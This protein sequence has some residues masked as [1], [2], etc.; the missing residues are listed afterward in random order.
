MVGELIAL[1][2]FGGIFN[3]INSNTSTSAPAAQKAAKQSEKNS[4]KNNNHL[5]GETTIK[6]VY[7]SAG[8]PQQLGNKIASGGQGTVY[9]LKDLPGVVVKIY[10]PATLVKH[11]KEFEE[12]LSAAVTKAK[13]FKNTAICWPA[14]LVYNEKKE[15]IGY[16]MRKAEG[17]MFSLLAHPKNSAKHFPGLQRSDIVKVLISLSKAVRLLHK[18]DIVVGDLNACNILVNQSTYEVTL[19]DCDS[20]QFNINGKQWYC[21]VGRPEL[22]APELQGKT[23]SRVLRPKES[24]YFSLAVLIFTGLMLGRSPY[25]YVGGEN[26]VDNLKNGYFPYG[27]KRPEERSGQLPRGPWYNIWS[28]FTYRLKSDFINTLG[29]GNKNISE[30]HTPEQWIE[31]LKDYRGCIKRGTHTDELMPAK[32][33]SQEYQGKSKSI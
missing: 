2:I 20:Y 32:P 5:Q 8:K 21:G 9:E 16:A 29:E 23:L 4:R 12:K 27:I 25:D 1:M 14:L 13:A 15:F 33:K 6:T 7:N 28:H 30:R 19:I 24:E 17:K 22:T 11:G 10:S 18:N 31:T 3:L 26:P